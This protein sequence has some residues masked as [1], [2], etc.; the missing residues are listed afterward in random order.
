MPPFHPNCR[1]TTT[2][3]FEDDD[4]PGERMMRDDKGK[5]VNTDYVSYDEWKKKY[6]DNF[7]ENDTFESLT[8]DEKRA[9]LMYKSSESYKINEKLYNE[10][11]LNYD[12]K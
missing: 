10:M 5:S 1:C 12:D 9:I 6:V 8:D 11:P 7:Y 4:L 2:V 3:Y